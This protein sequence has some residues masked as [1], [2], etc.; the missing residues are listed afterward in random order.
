M[1]LG[2]LRGLLGYAE[3]MQTSNMGIQDLQAIAGN[4]HCPLAPAER[5]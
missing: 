5:A 1:V 2:E 3:V 4:K